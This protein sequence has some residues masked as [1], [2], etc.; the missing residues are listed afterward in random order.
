[1]PILVGQSILVAIFVI[2]TAK[3]RNNVRV[4]LYPLKSIAST[5]W[6][7]PITASDYTL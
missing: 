4:C 3:F 1:M 6:C 5:W 7:N 2:G